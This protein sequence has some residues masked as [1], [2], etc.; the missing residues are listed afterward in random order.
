[1]NTSGNL[2]GLVGPIVVG[3]MVDRWQSW[4]YPFYVTAAVYAMGA[5]AWLLIDPNRRLTGTR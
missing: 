5:F 4:T 2:G 3:L 1:M